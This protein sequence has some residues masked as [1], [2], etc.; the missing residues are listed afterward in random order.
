MRSFAAQALCG[1]LLPLSAFAQP[2]PEQNAAKEAKTEKKKPATPGAGATETRIRAETQGGEKGHYWAKGYVDL[3]AG[4]MRIQ[5]D[6]LDLYET[7]KPDGN[8]QRQLVAVGNVVFLRGDERLSG[9][10]MTMD[11]D[12]GRGS[13]ENALGYVQ[14]GVFVEAREIER[15]DADTYRIHGGRFTSCAQPTPRWGFSASSATVD[16][17]D[18]VVARNVLFKVHQVPLLYLPLLVYPIKREQRST[19]LLLPH[20]GYSS[21]RGYNFGTGFFWAMGRSF[22]QTLYFDEY[23]RFGYGFGHEFRYVGN[24]P[25]RGTF[26]TYAFRPQG[27]GDLDYDIDWKAIQVLPAR[28]RVS[29]N[30]RQYSNLLFQ[31]RIQDSL[32][33][34]STRTQRGVLN[35]QNTFGPWLVQGLADSTETIFADGEQKVINRRLPTLRLSHSPQKLGKSGVVVSFEAKGENLVYG[36]Q[37]QVDSFSRFDANSEISRP[38]GTTFLQVT[39]RFNLRYTRYGKSNVDGVLEGPPLDRRFAESTVELRGPSV[40][41]VFNNEGGFYSPKFKHIIEPQVTWTYR[42]KVDR[43]DDIPRFDGTDYL[44]GTNE[45]QYGLL[46][47]VLAKRPGPTGKLGNHELFSWRVYS[48]YYV[49]LATGANR[50]DPNYS[51]VAFDPG[52][53]PSHYSPLLSQVRLRPTARSSVSIDLEYDL[54]FKQLRTL[55]LGSN[56]NYQRVTF[57]GSF[58]RALRLNADPALRTPIRDTIRGGGRF[59]ALPGRLTLEASSDYDFVSHQ[60]YSKR[61]MARWEVQCCGFSAE[62]LEFNY[63]ARVERQYRF[64]IE[65][66]NIGSV[67]NFMGQGA[68]VGP[69]LGG[70]R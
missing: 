37:D 29:V 22:D 70:Y 19:G 45:F 33:Q 43:F 31:Q 65:L 4:E 67:G 7:D 21:T 27:G 66:A 34:A 32:N 41:R 24:G 52:G 30:A 54:N 38:M 25:S 18:K 59:V 2:R 55:S 35:V 36:N 6:Q 64:A 39:P 50:F 49:N 12:S 9:E 51:S 40:S 14:P 61:A 28:W 16:V 46:Q 62:V 3:V 58:A 17:G 56:V 47:T 13:F 57:N 69:G 5:C 48:T 60:S 11:L 26:R 8:K 1:L 10:R 68:G 44:V 42:T 23:S 15:I 63:N 20:F 53:A